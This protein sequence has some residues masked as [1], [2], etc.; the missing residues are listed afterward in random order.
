MA[1]VER[2]RRRAWMIFL[3]EGCDAEKAFG[4]RAKTK[5]MQGHEMYEKEAEIHDEAW[6]L[7]EE[8]KLNKCR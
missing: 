4:S 2:G 6:G 7:M 5:K 3:F 1:R 8:V